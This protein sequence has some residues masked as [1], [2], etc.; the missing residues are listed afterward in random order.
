[1]KFDGSATGGRPP[2]A[3]AWD[4]GDGGTSTDQSPN[5]T[6][7]SVGEYLASLTVTDSKG[8]ISQKSVSVTVKCPPLSGTASGTPRSGDAPLTVQFTGSASGGCP[9]VTYRWEFGDGGTSDGRNPNHTYEKSGDYSA[10]LTITDSNGNTDRED[11]AVTVTEKFVPTPEKP[12]ILEG[13]NFATNKADLR[14]NAMRI[15]D[16]VAASL[17]ARPDVV[18]EVGGHTDADGSEQYNLNLSERR[19]KAVQDYLIK[20]GVPAA[21]LTYK[22]YGETQPIADNTTPEGKAKN[23]RVELRRM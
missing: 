1:M 18:V 22:G 11:F 20:K 12:V 19:A 14:E 2:L 21:Q 9:P 8:N 10:S 3:Y 15:L 7:Q 5:H 17:I 6:Y 13:V 4:F 16:L 23:R